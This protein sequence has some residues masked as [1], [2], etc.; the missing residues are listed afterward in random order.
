MVTLR[1][2]LGRKRQDMVLAPEKLR[3][4]WRKTVMKIGSYN[5]V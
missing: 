5:L 4:Q 3:V 2:A 1:Q